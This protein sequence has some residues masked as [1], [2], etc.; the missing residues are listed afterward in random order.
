MYT[1]SLALAFT[2]TAFTEIKIS[3]LHLCSIKYPCL[4]NKALRLSWC[5]FVNRAGIP[6]VPGTI[7]YILHEALNRVAAAAETRGTELH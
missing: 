3:V 5:D 1:G 7:S 2:F 4:T 6:L